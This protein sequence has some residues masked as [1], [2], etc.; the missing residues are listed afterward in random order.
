V[1]HD[2]DRIYS[3]DL[4][5][6]LKALGLVVLKAPYKSPQGNSFCERLIGTARRERFDF[7]IPMNEGHIRQTLKSWTEHYNLRRPHSSLGP[8]TPD[9][10]SPKADPQP[11]RHCIPKDCRIVATSIL[12]GLHHEYR[13][14]R[15]AA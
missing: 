12:G 11:Q 7:M 15:L 5:A 1:I 6:S 10:N 14:E 9:K 4:D 8:G 13:L 2:R 3:K